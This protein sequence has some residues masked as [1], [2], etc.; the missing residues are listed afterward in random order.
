MLLL[1][2]GRSVLSRVRTFSRDRGAVVVLRSCALWVWSWFRG[3]PGGGR[4]HGSFDW[5]GRRLPYFVHHYHYTWLNERAVEVALALDLL[6]HHPG[7]S[8]LEVGNVLGHY[9]PFEHTVV[10]KYERAAGVLNEDVADLDLGRQLDLV[11]AISTL[12]H[13]GLDEDVR[14]D[15]K[16]LRALERLRAH[17]AP[18]G[19]LWVTHPVGYNLALDERLRD[20]VPGLVRMRA[21]RREPTRNEWREVPLAQAWGTSYDR[22]LYT[23]HAIVV[24][25][26]DAREDGPPKSGADEVTDW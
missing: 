14:D 1:R 5:D 16:P 13:V 26:L 25:E 24:A 19:R 6:E 4:D 20:G 15:D 11:L 9:L 22:L 18:G 7:A 12:E 2:R 21:L 17:V 23:A 8:V 3:R 10:D